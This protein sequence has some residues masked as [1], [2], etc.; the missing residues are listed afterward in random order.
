LE[1]K[2]SLP[3][4]A[5]VPNMKHFVIALLV[6]SLAPLMG[7]RQVSADERVV[8]VFTWSDY[9]DPRVL[10]DFTKETGIKVVYDTYDSDAALETRLMLGRSG[11][12]VVVPSGP[13]LQRSIA[14][15]LLQRLD[16]SRLPNAENLSPDIMARLA[17]D[18]PGN[19]YAV[20]Y[21]WFT[22]GIAFDADKARERLGGAPLDSWDIIFKPD[23]LK[24]FTDCGVYVL[25]DG[26]NLFAIALNYLKFD[27]NTRNLAELRRA[28]DL[29]NGLRRNVKKF[30]S[31]EYIN[32]LANGDICLA[33]GWSGDSALAR[34]RAREADNGIDIGYDIPREGTVISL[35]NLA[36]PWDAPH[37]EEAYEFINFLLRP[38][39]AARNTNAIGFASGVADAEASVAPAIA[40]DKTV[41]A[42][43]ETMKHL[44]AVKGDQATQKF[45][46]REWTLITTGK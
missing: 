21:V 35:D 44:F 45:I 17:V 6:L 7:L 34:N 9:V 43:A 16:T 32:A 12:D 46:A 33:V 30:Q 42:D 28:A 15:G 8:N 23:L 1:G 22:A 4:S 24:K 29:L 26:P 39:I 40:N 5:K 10:E 3:F 19:E 37:V 13:V 38:D 14:A 25:D 31:S 36:I 11:Y 2:T 20:N 41:Y 18:D 27:P